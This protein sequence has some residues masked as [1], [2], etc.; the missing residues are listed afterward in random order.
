MDRFTQMELFVHTVELGSI[1]K[2]AEKLG[3]SNPAASRHLSALEDRL[4]AR[5]IERTTR[6]MWLTEG[7]PQLPPAVRRDAG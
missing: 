6:R 7:R 2:A 5:L 1:S 4:G 3:L